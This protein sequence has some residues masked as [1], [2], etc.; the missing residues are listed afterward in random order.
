MLLLSF[1]RLYIW[2]SAAHGKLGMGKCEID[3][4]TATPG[5]V[6]FGLG[7]V[8]FFYLDIK[9]T[10]YSPIVMQFDLIAGNITCNATYLLLHHST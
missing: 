7:N 4:Y 2:G 6:P 3:S 8:R 1:F 9:N 10:C 5:Q